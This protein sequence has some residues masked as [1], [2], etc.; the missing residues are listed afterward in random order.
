[1]VAVTVPRL[2][3]RLQSA[4]PLGPTVPATLESAVG[5]AS[6]VVTASPPTDESPDRM[7]ATS[8]APE[9]PEAIAARSEVIAPPARRSTFSV[10]VGAF[11]NRE[12]AVR[13]Q[14]ELARKHHPATIHATREAGAPY[15]V[16][17]GRYPDR[18]AAE[19]AHVVLTREGFAGFVV[20][21]ANDGTT[22][23]SFAARH[24]STSP[25]AR[26]R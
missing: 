11:K 7:V 3:E 4:A 2:L 12:N 15:A 26:R 21:D 5:I 22:R 1:M 8:P 25:A 6:G 13:L 9:A 14:A 10:Q 19:A 20:P 18:R 24:S 23:S 16:Q 17:V